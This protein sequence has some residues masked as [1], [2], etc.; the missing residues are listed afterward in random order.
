MLVKSWS[1]FTTIFLYARIVAIMELTLLSLNNNHDL[2]DF[3]TAIANVTEEF[4]HRPSIS[5][6]TILVK[7]SIRIH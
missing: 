3:A 5:D 6:L 4:S 7:I 1:L 2:N